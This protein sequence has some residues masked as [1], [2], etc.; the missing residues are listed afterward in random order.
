RTRRHEEE[1]CLLVEEMR[2]VLTYLL[3]KADWWE[4]QGQRRDQSGDS[5]VKSNPRLAH[6]LLA[7]ASRQASILRDLAK[8]FAKLWLPPL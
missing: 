5:R 6:G 3:A 7:Y 8:V 2:R 4:T 1:I